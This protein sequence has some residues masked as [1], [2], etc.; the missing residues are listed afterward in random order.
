MR[1][2]MNEMLIFRLVRQ[3]FIGQAIKIVRE[4]RRS[5]EWI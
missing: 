4:E 5:R 1:I 2:H 3:L